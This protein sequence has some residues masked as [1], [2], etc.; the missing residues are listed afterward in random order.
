VRPLRCRGGFSREDD[1]GGGPAPQPILG[2]CVGLARAASAAPAKALRSSRRDARSNAASE[3]SLS[4]TIERA[5]IVPRATALSGATEMPDRPWSVWS[6]V[7]PGRPG[8][9][10]R[11]SPVC[12][13]CPAIGANAPK[14]LPVSSG[15][16]IDGGAQVNRMP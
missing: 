12:P 4:E 15:E 3:P 6:R 13:G 5:S 8:M 7:S 9:D 10:V 16:P 11:T 14:A 2:E 1:G